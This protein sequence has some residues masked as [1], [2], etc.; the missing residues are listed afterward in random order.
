[1]M[2]TNFVGPLK[3]VLVRLDCIWEADTCVDPSGFALVVYIASVYSH[4]RCLN[5]V[6]QLFMYVL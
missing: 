6:Q 1:M 5:G 3:I 2:R 4:V